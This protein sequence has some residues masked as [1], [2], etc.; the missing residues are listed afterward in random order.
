MKKIQYR[1]WIYIA[2]AM[3]QLSHADS[4]ASIKVQDGFTATQY[5][6]PDLADDIYSMTLDSKGRVVVS[7]RGYIRTLHDTNQ[8]GIADKSIQFAK[9]DR[10]TM[11]MLFDDQYLW[12]VA[13]RA[14]LRFVDSDHD[15][16]ADG[17]PSQFLRLANGEHG[18]HAIRKGPDGWLYLVGGNNTGFTPNQFNSLNSPLKKT[19]GGAIIRFSPNGK[20]F[21]ALSCGFRNPYDFDF[22]WRGDIF[23][24]DSDTERTFFLPWYTPTRLYHVAIGGH[25]GWRM[26][27]FKR[28]WARPSYYSDTVPDIHKIG[29]GSPTGVAV[30]SHHLLPKEMQDGIFILDWTF[31]NIWFYPLKAANASYQSLPQLFISP[32]GNDGFAPSDIEVGRDGELFIST[33]GRGTKGSVFRVIP[34]KNNS[35]ETNNPKITKNTSIEALLNAPQPMAEWSRA[36]W[37]PLAKKFGVIHLTEAA[38]NPNRKPKQRV[39]AI[40]ILTD[41]FSGLDADSAERLSK[42]FSSDIRARTAWAIGRY[43]SVNATQLLNHLALD[44]EDYVR[45]KA[46]EAM[47]RL[48]PLAPSQSAEWI[49]TLYDNFNQ[50]S[51]RV[52][53]IS[54]RLASRLP[55]S[56]WQKT[57]HNK[58]TT[59]GKVT[60]ITAEIWRNS[61]KEIHIQSIQNLLPLINS[62]QKANLNLDIVR[63]IILALGDYNLERPSHESFTG[64]ESPYSLTPHR[65]LT[66]TIAIQITPLMNTSHQD[67]KREASRLLAMVSAEQ[68]EVIRN[69]LH[70][71]TLETNPVEDFHKLIVM[72]KLPSSLISGDLQK[73]ANAL[74]QLDT[75]LKSQ[76]TRPKLNWTMRFADIAQAHTNKQPGLIKKIIDHENFPTASHLEFA[77]MLKG[78]N[79][80]AAAKRYLEATKINQ[81]L[82]WSNELIDLLAITPQKNLLPILRKQWS[83]RGLRPAII[84]HLVKQPKAQDR[85]LLLDALLSRDNNLSKTALGALKQLPTSNKPS[86]FSPLIRKLRRECGT[87]GKAET[88]KKILE[89][90]TSWSGHKFKKVQEKNNLTIN[91]LATWQPVFDWFNTTYPDLAE[92]A[93]DSGLVNS[94]KWESILG[95]VNWSEGKLIRGKKIFV[96][97]ACQNCHSG[98]GALG[99]NL[100]GAV[101]RLAPEDLF[102]TILFPNRDI[103]PLYRFNEYRMHNGDVHLGRAAFYAADGIVLKTGSGIIRLDQKDIASQHTSERSIMP[104]GLLEGLKA[105]D[106]ADLYQYLKSL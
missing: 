8:D 43:P 69:L 50:T 12:V 101:K 63:T 91:L 84:K 56:I 31:G 55:K 20:K 7:G 100:I 94:T 86:D 62:N 71:I 30:Y 73:L 40:E 35:E 45:V 81:K 36:Q 11:G 22:N 75:K 9:V 89:L 23:T 80:L 70:E 106:L 37:K 46:L 33:G 51:I 14:L 16:K 105:N 25:H 19:E 6:G 104:E 98:A 95:I 97:R 47:L 96:N 39:R 10:G 76:G 42:S 83:N 64:Y 29:R 60:A 53:L 1:I 58:L 93:S 13:N 21:E 44:Q 79:R 66:Q 18:A 5:A 2:I 4:E 103:S 92:S 61:E 59:Q 68:P 17:P 48:L 3:S 102:R 15:G 85:G 49:D 41:I 72:A 27:G 26:P 87:K 24:Y 67:L 52:R 78:D 54:A 99:P 74:M 34:T 32:L 57:N 77:L 65:S 82:P 90:L 38:L 28:S 88:R